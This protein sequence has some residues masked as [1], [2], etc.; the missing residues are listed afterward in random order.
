MDVP[1]VVVG[2]AGVV[3]RLLQRHVADALRLEPGHVRERRRRGL[4]RSDV[5]KLR[6]LQLEVEG[7]AARLQVHPQTVR[8][9]LADSLKATIS[10]RLLPREHVLGDLSER[11]SSPGQYVLD[12]IRTA[13][14]IIVSFSLLLLL[15]VVPII[16][17]TALNYVAGLSP[18]RPQRYLL[19]TFIGMVPSTYLF[20]YFVDATV[21]GIMEPRDVLLRRLGRPRDG[22]PARP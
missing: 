10:Q 3:V 4:G 16:P 9:R 17:Y 5:A 14:L 11:Y 1:E 7:V 21:E 22:H 19:A 8:Y 15:R 6:E 18:I 2:H 12:A 13:P 20:A